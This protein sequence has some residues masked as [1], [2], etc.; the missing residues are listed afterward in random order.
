MQ[1]IFITG[2]DTG[3]GKTFV[4]A[5]IAS[6]L[7]KQ[8]VNV[9]VMK[10]VHTGCKAKNGALIPQDSVLLARSAGV[11]D[12]LDLMTPYMFRE[13]VAPYVAA[14]ENDIEIDIGRITKSFTRLCRRHEYMIVEGIGGVLVPITQNFYVAD[15]IK[16]LR[17]PAIVV[18]RPGLG[19]I[20]HTI[21]TINCLRERKIPIKGIVVNYSLKEKDTLAEKR[22]PETIGRLSRVPILGIIPCLSKGIPAGANPFLKLAD[23]LFDIRG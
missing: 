23:S 1:G 18:T 7:Q 22:G 17:L 10:P 16:R 9:G 11:D 15:L 3:V 8:R 5:G 12:P 21:L 20:N 19:T 4:A 2:T 14:I 6:A 13:P